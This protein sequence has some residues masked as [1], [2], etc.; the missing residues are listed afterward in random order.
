MSS[1]K[2]LFPTL[3]LPRAERPEGTLVKAILAYLR[4]R[5]IPSWRCNVGAATFQ[6]RRGGKRFVRFNPAGTPD[7]LGTIPPTGRLIAVECKRLPNGPTPEQCEF[8]EM[9]RSAGAVAV[10]AFT[11]ADVEEALRRPVPNE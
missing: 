3:R 9:L 5:G 1:C 4:S 7:I 11:V 10:V 6:D 8:L 2:L